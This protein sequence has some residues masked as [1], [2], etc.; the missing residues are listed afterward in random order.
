[1][2]RN[3]NSKISFSILIL[4][5]KVYIKISSTYTTTQFIHLDWKMCYQICQT[6]FITSSQRNAPLHL[7]H[8]W[9]IGLQQSLQCYCVW[10]R[11][12]ATLFQTWKKRDWILL[13]SSMVVDGAHGGEWE[14]ARHTFAN[15]TFQELLCSHSNPKFCSRCKIAILN[16]GQ[17]DE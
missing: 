15:L 14:L 16:G 17:K 13:S 10:R 7:C 9:T 1:M 12:Y 6:A 5:R 4:E 11:A 8:V 2:N 3:C